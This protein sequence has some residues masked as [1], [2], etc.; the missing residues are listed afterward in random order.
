MTKK[1]EKGGLG[2]GVDAL[3]DDSPPTP[4][5]ERPSPTP[6]DAALPAPPLGDSEMRRFMRTAAFGALTAM[7]AGAVSVAGVCA[8]LL[9][10]GKRR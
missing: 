1:K 7:A 9:A 4:A 3:I 8:V 2:R 5:A 10:L 6:A